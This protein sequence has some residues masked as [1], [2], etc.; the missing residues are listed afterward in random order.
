LLN[1]QWLL[2]GAAL[3]MAAM[4][5]VWRRRTTKRIE[6]LSQ[7]YWELRY[8]LGQLNA[9]VG[10]LE[11]PADPNGPDRVADMPAQ[12]ASNFVPLSSLRK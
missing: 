4:A 5:L 10:R 1:L 8:E 12:P 7:S 3:L 11:P 9:R 2:V 6:R